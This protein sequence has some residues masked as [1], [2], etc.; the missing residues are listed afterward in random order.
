MVADSPS[1]VF[2]IRVNDGNTS[3]SMETFSTSRVRVTNA[4]PVTGVF[5]ITGTPTVS[6]TEITSY[7]LTINSPGIRSTATS[8]T[9]IITL[10][11]EQIILLTSSASSLNQEVCD[12]TAIEEVV[13]QLE[14][15]ASTGHW[16]LILDRCYTWRYFSAY[17]FRK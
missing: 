10:N 13:F 1:Y 11:P 2:W 5:S 7:T 4:I 12:N 6:I 3:G 9:T 17:T 8:A 14:G 16:W 15:S